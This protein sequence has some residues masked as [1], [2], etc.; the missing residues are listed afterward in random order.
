MTGAVMMHLFAGFDPKAELWVG[1][2][3]GQ[4]IHT[5]AATL[6]DLLAKVWAMIRDLT[7]DGLEVSQ[8]IVVVDMKSARGLLE[9]LHL[10][11]SPAN[12][13]RLDESI[14]DANTG[15]VSEFRP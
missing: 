10:E 15:K 1:K 13:K 14:A 11:R 3:E 5:E 2:V 9:T 4:P 12:A 6:D 7:D 8:L